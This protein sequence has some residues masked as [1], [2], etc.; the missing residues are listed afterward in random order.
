MS[1][2]YHLHLGDCLK[3][4]PELEADAFDAVI[5][6]PPYSSGGFTRSDRSNNPSKKY[7]STGTE[8][9]RAS[10]SGD[11]RD[12]R[13][14]CY[15]CALWISECFRLV[16]EGGYCLVFCD[17]RQLPLASDALQAGGFV[18]RGVISWDKTDCA[19]A[20]HKGYF[21]HQCE[22][23]VWG[24]KGVS[25]SASHGGPWAGA[26]RIP[27]RQADKHHMTGKPTALLS[28]LVEC[29]PPEGAVLDPFMG[30]GTTGV[31][32]L[33]KGRRFVGVEQTREYFAIAR[34]AGPE[35]RGRLQRAGPAT[36]TLSGNRP[37]TGGDGRMIRIFVGDSLEVLRTLPSSSVHCVVTS[38]PYWSLR[39][40]GV[41]G[42][43]GLEATPEE[44]AEILGAVFLEVRRVLREDGTLWINYGDAYNTCNGGPGPSSS[45]LWARRRALHPTG[46]GFG[47]KVKGLARK[48]LIGL[49]WRL[50]FR[51]QADGWILRNEIIWSKPNPTPNPAAT[52]RLAKSHEHVFLFVKSPRY[53]FRCGPSDGTVWDIAPGQYKGAHTS[54]SPL[55]LVD[56]CLEH[57]C[58]PGGVVLDPFAGAGTTGLVAD[59]RG[60][61]ATL[62]ELNES[63]AAEARDRIVADC[64]LFAK[65]EMRAG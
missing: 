18:W 29:V 25:V 57:G 35:R 44:H 58:P 40:Y 63:S 61:H 53:Y 8:I 43:V 10:F 3:V 34:V 52:D 27:V 14:W 30:S 11:G 37:S 50:A 15:W 12:G 19:R 39:D 47:L 16:C 56:R 24:T 65:V 36:G 4:L 48:S 20:P 9:V 21:R 32:A 23:V 64:P 42:Q 17:W 7:V 46:R 60:L 22:Y 38:P 13:S 5:T 2:R 54:T 6:D 59:R 26:Y 45:R 33:A 28:E 1:Q 51:L 31:A 41:D 62:I 49:S 55:D